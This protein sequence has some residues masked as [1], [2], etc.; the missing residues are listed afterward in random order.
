[1]SI[2]EQTGMMS[3]KPRPYSA[4]G[5]LFLVILLFSLLAIV[6]Y[7]SLFSSESIDPRVL[8][9]GA[10]IIALVLILNQFRR[11][12]ARLDKLSIISDAYRSGRLRCAFR[13]QQ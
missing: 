6:Y 4:I 10:I 3:N 12:S 5:S 8:M 13:G 7:P 11:I 1:M 2:R 9:V